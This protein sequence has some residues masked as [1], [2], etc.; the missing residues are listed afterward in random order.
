[1]PFTQHRERFADA[2]GG[3]EVD[4]QFSPRVARITTE[5]GVHRHSCLCPGNRREF[6]ERHV[7]FQHVD[8]RLTEEAEQ[9][10]L[11]VLGNELADLVFGQAALAGHSRDLDFGRRRADMRI[12]SAAGSSDKVNRDRRI[13]ARSFSSRMR[14]ISWVTRSTR[15]W[16]VGPSFDP[17]DSVAS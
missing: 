2:G 12:E 15:R 10:A 17:S 11:R 1:M 14:A 7:Q 4:A 3:T 13:G 8:A 9:A 6:V 5:V 16:L